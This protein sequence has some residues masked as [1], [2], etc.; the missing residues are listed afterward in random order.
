MVAVVR[1]PRDPSTGTS[2]PA[3]VGERL[4]TTR[5]TRGI[6]IGALA[7]AAGVGKGSLSEIENGTRN[8]TLATLYALAGAL[9]VPMSALLAE[10]IGARVDAPGV[11]TMLVDVRH[12]DAATVEVYRLDLDADVTYVSAGHATGVTEHLL[13]TAGRARV[14][15]GGEQVDLDTGQ[16]ATWL[17][18][19]EHTY[20]AL[21]GRAV[22]S[23]LVITSPIISEPTGRP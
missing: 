11:H 7:S 17:S 4:R 12:T 16:A 22:E 2:L 9:G 1:P 14:G 6:S 18:D 21:D 8:P 10:Q 23:V 19:V 3:V 5:R 15:R 20:A 13:V